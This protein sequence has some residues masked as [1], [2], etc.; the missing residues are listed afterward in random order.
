M[1]EKLD[2][3]L[4]KVREILKNEC[5]NEAVA[6]TIFFNSYGYNV[7]VETRSPES[8]KRDGISMK[9]LRGLFIL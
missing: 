5:S 4:K 1:S 6:V 3:A 7:E 8:L 9:N 2:E